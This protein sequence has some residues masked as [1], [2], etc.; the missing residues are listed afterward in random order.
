SALR[1]TFTGNPRETRDPMYTPTSPPG[2]SHAR[3]LKSQLAAWIPPA[4]A[5]MINPNSRFVPTTKAG[6]S[7]V[8]LNSMTVPSAPAP[9]EE[10]PVSMPRIKLK[11]G[12][13]YARDLH[14]EFAVTP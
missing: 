3:A 9:A 2:T 12:S 4:V 5:E 10:K 7:S 13:R 11:G 14:R 1:S 8:R 6:D